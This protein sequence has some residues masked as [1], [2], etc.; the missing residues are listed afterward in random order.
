M[1]FRKYLSLCLLC[2]LLCNSTVMLNPAPVSAATVI[3][4]NPQP[5]AVAPKK[6]SQSPTFAQL[7][8]VSHSDLRGPSLYI[9][10]LEHPPVASYRGGIAGLDA[11]NP[12]VRGERKL[13]VQN[14]P[15]R[16]YAAHLDALHAQTLTEMELVLD[17]SPLGSARAPWR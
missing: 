12:Q 2:V 11:T 9:I 4:I 1:R 13:D 3:P 10:L 7:E 17:R 15:S 8:S 14:T 16:A 5:P 6:V